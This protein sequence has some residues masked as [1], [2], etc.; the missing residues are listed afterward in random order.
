MTLLRTPFCGQFSWA[1]VCLT[2][3]S[4]VGDRQR[5]TQQAGDDGDETG[6]SDT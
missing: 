2:G 6:R 1:V 5:G 4:G 3:S